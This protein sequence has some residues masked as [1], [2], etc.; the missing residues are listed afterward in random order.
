M[1][2]YKLSAEQG[3]PDAQYSL[4][5]CYES[6]KGVKQNIKEAKKWYTKAAKQGDEQAIQDL[7]KLK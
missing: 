1:K 3:N 7:E 2:W 5:Y 6:G 4:G